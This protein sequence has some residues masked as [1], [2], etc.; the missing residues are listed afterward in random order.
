LVLQFK[1]PNG[2]VLKDANGKPLLGA[3]VL[4]LTDIFDAASGDYITTTESWH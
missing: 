3:G 4:T 1:I 2:P